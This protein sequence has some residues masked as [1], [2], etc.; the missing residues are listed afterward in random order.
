MP[1]AD[2][3]RPGALYD[4]Y[5]D[6]AVVHHLFAG[7]AAGAAGLLIATA[8]KI[9]APLRTN[10]AGIAIALPAS[11]SSPSSLSSPLL[12]LPLLVTLG[13]LRAPDIL[14]AWRRAS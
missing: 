12:R 10:P 6:D 9:A 1:H 13:T 14:M 4:R 8:V 5:Q 11:F 3:H 7:L 2:R